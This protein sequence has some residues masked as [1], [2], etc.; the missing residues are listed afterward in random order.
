M[1]E[2]SDLSPRMARIMSAIWHDVGVQ[3]CASR[4]KDYQ[5]FDSAIFFLNSLDRVSAPNYIPTFDDMLRS[6][7]K[8]TGIV[9]MQ[10]NFK[11]KIFLT[12]HN[13]TLL[14]YIQLRVLIAQNKSILRIVVF[15]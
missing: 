10:F 5:L 4:S 9:E 8:T 2:D 12:V 14:K 6:R 1:T 7:I 3:H 11:V 13:Y 15:D